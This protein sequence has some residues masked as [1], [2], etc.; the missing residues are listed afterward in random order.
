MR[1]DLVRNDPEFVESIGEQIVLLPCRNGLNVSPPQAIGR[2]ESFAR[3][4][5][6]LDFSRM[7]CSSSIR[8]IDRA[9]NARHADIRRYGER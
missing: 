4:S 9:A 8:K 2:A 3:R 1:D 7:R 6:A 5:R